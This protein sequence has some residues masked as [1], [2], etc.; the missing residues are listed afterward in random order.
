M[1]SSVLLSASVFGLA[2]LGVPQLA[3]AGAIPYQTPGVPITLAT[4]NFTGTGGDVTAYYA[5]S[6]AGDT[7]EVGMFVWNGTSY[8]QQGGWQF[9]NHAGIP[10]GT[11]VDFGAVG[12]G[13]SIEFVLWNVS[14]G[15]FLSSIAA[16]NADGFNHAYATAA[17]AGQAYGGS[18]AGTFVGF[19]DLLRQQGSDFDYNDDTYVFTQVAGVA[20]LPEPGTLSLLGIAMLGLG[21]LGLRKKLV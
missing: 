15:D 14:A 6:S 1:K 7:D 8:V 5:G 9:N 12:A 2:L 16:D 21:A 19:E 18:P 3:S 13:V 10:V 20:P 4:Y 11:S 17:A